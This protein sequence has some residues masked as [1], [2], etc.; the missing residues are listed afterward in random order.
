M[1]WWPLSEITVVEELLAFPART[2]LR[3]QSDE[4]SFVVKVTGADPSRD[5][6]RAVL[7]YLEERDF[8]H[9]PRLLRTRTGEGS[10]LTSNTTVI[11]MEYL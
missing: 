4:G 6:A 11:V 3:I 5:N 2:V 1:A 7:E 9:S 10:V 8:P